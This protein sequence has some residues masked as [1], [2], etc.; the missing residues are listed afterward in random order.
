MNNNKYDPLKDDIMPVYR[1]GKEILFEIIC[2]V[3]Q[4]P[5]Q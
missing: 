1:I 5:W 3:Q 4:T 2:I